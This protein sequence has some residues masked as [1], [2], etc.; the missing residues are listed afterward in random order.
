LTRVQDDG[1]ISAAGRKS[2]GRV[3][4]EDAGAVTASLM[5]AAAS[6]KSRR[7]DDAA[8]YY[9]SDNGANGNGFGTLLS[10]FSRETR[11][12]SQGS[13]AGSRASQ[14]GESPARVEAA[15]VT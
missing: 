11:S 10:V 1:R 6:G 3:G 14:R 8:R 9:N 5:A 4:G 2:S 7:S 15:V 12:R 13:G